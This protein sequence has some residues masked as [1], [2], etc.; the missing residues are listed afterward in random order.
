MFIIRRV[1]GDS[2]MPTL[3]P[4][5]IVVA[6]KWRSAQP[7]DIVV[8]KHGGIEKIK[9]VTRVRSGE[10]FVQGDNLARST[11]S[12]TFGWLPVQSIE[13]KVYT[14]SKRTLL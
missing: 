9:R 11:D 2:M 8:I 3:Q 4:G 10:V 14:R 1:H 13:G 12:R 5:K 7:G 6:L